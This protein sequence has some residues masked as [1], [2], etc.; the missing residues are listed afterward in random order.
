MEE[1]RVYE[2]DEVINNKQE[3]SKDKIT[4]F[5]ANIIV[6]KKVRLS[7]LVIINPIK[8]TV[9]IVNKQMCNDYW[10]PLFEKIN[11]RYTKLYSN[12]SDDLEDL[13]HDPAPCFEATSRCHKV[14]TFDS[15]IG[16]KNAKRKYLNALHKYYIRRFNIVRNKYKKV[17][18]DIER[19]IT[20]YKP[21]AV[22][23]G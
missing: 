14:D 20:R 19:E 6:C 1:E 10:Q 21:K 13:Y 4:K 16:L 2:L 7:V 11:S 15:I 3:F 5:K 18:D 9:T 22:N 23:R 8:E 17:F 12:I